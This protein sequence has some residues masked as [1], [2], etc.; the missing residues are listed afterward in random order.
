MTDNQ[1]DYNE[2][3]NLNTDYNPL[4]ETN[5][6]NN[7]EPRKY[8]QD[9]KNKDKKKPRKSG[10]KANVIRK[11]HTHHTH[12]EADTD[13]IGTI[14]ATTKK[15]DP[16]LIYEAHVSEDYY[17]LAW[18]ALKKEIWKEKEVYGV[19]IFF[20]HSDYIR[21]AIDFTMFALMISFTIFVMLWQ[22]FSEG[23]FK[24]GSWR[25]EFL[26]IIIVALAQRLLL[27]EF[28]KGT[29]KLRYALRHSEEFNYP[30]FA[31]FIPFWQILMSLI[32]YCLIVIFMCVSNEALP[33]VMHFAEVAILI[34]LDDWLGE[35]ICKEYP[36][37]GPKPDD[38]DVE[39]LNDEM[40][41]KTKLSM[42]RE[43]L[44]II[45]DYN[46]PYNSVF[47]EYSA[48]LFTCIPWYILP[49]FSTLS[50]EYIL[51]YYRPAMVEAIV[52]K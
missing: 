46:L 19:P 9:S 25:I 51:K 23:V 11:H 24:M 3:D 47:M 16:L 36:D 8:S 38:V 35:M 2:L 49:F 14:E 45:S 1:N 39:N 31:A 48:K 28:H 18:C 4:L 44:K 43:D 15:K 10:H 22:T 41:M 34:E 29:T 32:S 13:Y 17:A 7:E 12:T 52:G 21:L 37:E 27:P 20:T 40:S 50:F 6:S 33:L 42:V 26:R 5:N 30:F